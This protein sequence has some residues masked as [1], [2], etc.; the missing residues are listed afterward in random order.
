M[1]SKCPNCGCQV[2]IKKSGTSGLVTGL[3]M[4]VV[5]VLG[6]FVVWHQLSVNTEHDAA[7]IS[8]HIGAM[9]Q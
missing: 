2:V 8:G 6:G 3:G 9:N 7:A 5:A 4:I 1:I